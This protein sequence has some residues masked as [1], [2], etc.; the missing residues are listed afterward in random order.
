MS[1]DSRWA[2]EIAC[3]GHRYFWDERY[4]KIAVADESGDLPPDTADGVM[5]LDTG[6]PI[7]MEDG[8]WYI[9]LTGYRDAESYS[10][11]TPASWFEV[12]AVAHRWRMTVK[13]KDT[14]VPVTKA[15]NAIKPCRS[16]GELGVE[17]D[18]DC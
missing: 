11:K 1:V 18:W 8:Q 17:H 7:V 14:E 12:I 4:A 16:C 9:P 6:S 5:H 15:L 13:V 3:D 2:L 10:S